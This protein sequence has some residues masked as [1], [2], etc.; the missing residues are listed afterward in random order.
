MENNS[1]HQIIQNNEVSIEMDLLQV[2]SEPIGMRCHYCQED[3]MTKAH[4]R[5][6]TITHIFAVIL[7][8]FFW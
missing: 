3:I 5:S 6:T 7:G 1:Y 8:V 4:Y 2:G